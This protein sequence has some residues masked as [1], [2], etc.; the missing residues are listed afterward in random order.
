VT[1]KYPRIS[2]R[3]TDDA[4]ALRR[5]VADLTHFIAQARKEPNKADNHD[6]IWRVAAEV[7][8]LASCIRWDAM[9]VNEVVEARQSAKV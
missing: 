2:T 7:E 9:S 1:R 3:I 8:R 6:C 4:I 5:A